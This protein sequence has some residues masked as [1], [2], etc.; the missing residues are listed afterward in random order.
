[1]LFFTKVGKFLDEKFDIALKT[2]KEEGKPKV[3][4][5]FKN[6]DIKT[7][8]INRNDLVSLLD[9]QEKIKE[10]G[11]FVTHFENIQ[12]LKY[13]FGNQLEKYLKV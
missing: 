3:Y 8:S 10:I 4:T 1:M 12:D 5:Y 13:Q 11:H 9:F 6:A 7:G 2:F